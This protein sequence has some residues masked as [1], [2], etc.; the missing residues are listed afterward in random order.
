M[1]GCV[2]KLKRVRIL[3]AEVKRKTIRADR[4]CIQGYSPVKGLKGLS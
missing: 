4:E 2:G 1:R 3:L